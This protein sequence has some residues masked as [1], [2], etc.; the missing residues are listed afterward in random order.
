MVS[1]SQLSVEID[2]NGIATVM[3]NRPDRLNA[4]GAVMHAELSLVFREL[5]RSPDVRVIILT[6]AGK[7][8]SA[9]GDIEWMQ[10]MIDDPRIFERTI[11]EAKE[12]ILSM[13]DCEKPIIGQI[14]GHA[15]GLG[16]TLALFCDITFMADTAKI[17]DPHVAMGLVAADGGAVIWPQLVGYARAKEYLL[18]GDLLKAADAERIGLVNHVCSLE[19]LPGEVSTL[20]VRL[21]AGAQKAI[22]WTKATVNIGLK[23]LADQMLDAGL[24]YEAVTNLSRDHQAAVTAFREGRKPVFE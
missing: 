22:R 17:G 20:A 3:L 11:R 14:N 1:Y 13:L 12:I 6:G 21:A 15:T 19:A 8:F 4:A 7:A 5:E 16:A 9:G 2:P 24:A 18:T 23:Q 10:E